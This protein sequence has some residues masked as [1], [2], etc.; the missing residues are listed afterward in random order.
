MTRQ[1]SSRAS[2]LVAVF[3]ALSCEEEVLQQGQIQY[4][5]A[6]LN[7]ALELDGATT[8][9]EIPSVPAQ[10][11][12][13]LTVEVKVR[14]DTVYEGSHP[15]ISEA[16]EDQWNAASGFSLKY[17]LGRI[18]WR[19][20]RAPNLASAFTRAF[21]PVANR[22]YHLS[23]TFDGQ[24]ARVF[25]DGV[26]L[27]EEAQAFSISYGNRGIR[28]G[29]SLNSLFHGPVYFKGQIDEVRLWNHARPE[30]QIVSLM[31]QP[32]TGNEVGLVGYWNFDGEIDHFDPAE[33]RSPAQ[34]HGF[35][36]GKVRFVHSTAFSD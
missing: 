16:H 33:D 3:F 28:I 23:C 26:L 34:N 17:E 30:E 12:A 14:F 8:F 18:H 7:Y 35:V 27:H 6:E 21:S 1:P 15:F 25:V 22:W 11:P 20:A 31:R 5:E 13:Q 19:L 32:L 29:Y 4:L 2:L 36:S 10:Q 9:V 24:T